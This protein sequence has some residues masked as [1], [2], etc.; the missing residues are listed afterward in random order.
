[1][2]T[3]QESA[4]HHRLA[5]QVFG[6]RDELIVSESIIARKRGVAFRRFTGA[7][8]AF[9]AKPPTIGAVFHLRRCLILAPRR[10]WCE[11]LR[12]S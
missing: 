12:G 4:R 5:H 2:L 8:L 3:W 10:A 1:M 9:Q 11:R 6:F 7:G